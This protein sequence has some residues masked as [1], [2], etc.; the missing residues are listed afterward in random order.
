MTYSIEYL[1]WDESSE[2]IEFELD[3][4][5]KS[6]AFVSLT[7]GS[8]TYS[9]PDY[10]RY[11]DSSCESDSTRDQEFEF[12]NLASN[13]LTA[14][15]DYQITVALVGLSTP[16]PSSSNT[17]TTTLTSED[18]IG[19]DE[20]G[21]EADDFGSL[22][23]T[24]FVY[25]GETYTVEHLKWDESSEE[26]E[27][28]L[29][30]CLK[31]SVFIS[32]AI[33][34]TTYSNPDYTRRSETYCDSNASAYQEF[35]FHDITSNPLTD[36]AD[37]QITVT[38]VGN[39]TPPDPSNTT[40]TTTLTSEDEP[41]NDEFG[42]EVDDF[43]SLSDATFVYDGETYTVEYLKWD[44]S[45]DEIEFELDR[46]LKP[47][48]FVS[49]A[50]GSTTYSNPDYTRRS[51]TYC[52]S[53][54]SAYQEFEFHDIT[55]NPLTDGAD[56]QIT[57]TLVGISTP[58]D[59]GNTTWTTTLTSEDEP[60]DDEFGYEA[61]DFGS[62]SDATFEYDG[63]TYTVVY[64]KWDES[65]DEIEFE[66]DRCLKPS[67][68]ISLAIG[69]TTYSN[70]DYTRRSETYCDSN[71]SAYQEFEFHDITS[72]PL[73]AGTDYQITVTL[74]GNSSAPPLFTQDS[75]VV[76]ITENVGDTT[77][78]VDTSASDPDGGGIDYS[79]VGGNVGD[80]FEISSRG[81]ISLASG[82]S[83][84]FE[85][86]SIY[87][88]TLKAEDRQT[89]SRYGA[90]SAAI[91]VAN[92]NESPSFD[93]D[94]YQFAIPTGTGSDEIL[95]GAVR[96]ADPDPDDTVV[97]TIASG[98]PADRNC[99]ETAFGSK[100]FRMDTLGR[101]WACPTGLIGTAANY[102]L[103]V[104]ATD[105]GAST[106]TT[107]VAVKVTN[108][109]IATMIL[110][111]HR[112]AE[113]DEFGVS[114][115]LSESRAAATS[116]LLDIDT[117]PPSSPR[118]SR[119]PRS[120]SRSFTTPNAQ[121]RVDFDLSSTYGFDYP[122][123]RSGSRDLLTVETSGSDGTEMAAKYVVLTLGLNEESSAVISNGVVPIIV[124]DK[125]ISIGES[126][127]GEWGIIPS[128]GRLSEPNERQFTFTVPSDVGSKNVQI[129]LTSGYRDPILTLEDSA[130]NVVE[131]ND[132]GGAGFN[133]R[134]V[135]H[136]PAGSYKILAF[137]RWAGG[138]GDFELTISYSDEPLTDPDD[139]RSE[140]PEQA[141]PER[142]AV[143][144]ESLAITGYEWLNG[145]CADGGISFADQGDAVC[146]EAAGSGFQSDD[147]AIAVLS[148]ESADYPIALPVA[149][150]ALEYEDST[151][152]RGKWVAQHLGRFADS[153][154][155]TVYSMTIIGHTGV[156][157]GTLSVGLPSAPIQTD[158]QFSDATSTLTN[159]GL[160]DINAI[161]ET[162]WAVFG[163]GN[164]YTNYQDFTI[165]F[166]KGAT[167]GEWGLD[168]NPNRSI[169]YFVGW[170]VI[171][172]IPGVDI[173]PDLR[174]AIKLEVTRCSG[175]LGCF[176]ASLSDAVDFLA[177]IP[178]I[179]KIGDFVQLPKI[180]KWA[181]D[182]RTVRKGVSFIKE[183]P[184]MVKSFWNG[185]RGHWVRKSHNRGIILQ[186]KVLNRFYPNGIDL[187]KPGYPSMPLVDILV[188]GVDADNAD[189]VISVKS[190]N[191]RDETYTENPS[192]IFST[193]KSRGYNKLK[194]EMDSKIKSDI[195]MRK[196]HVG[197]SMLKRSLDV[198]IPPSGLNN[199]NQVEQLKRLVC[200]G[201]VDKADKVADITVTIYYGNGIG[202]LRKWVPDE[203][204]DKTACR[205]R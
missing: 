198:V 204:L 184:Y 63:E 112:L 29:D 56:Y 54:A 37:Y 45:Q 138:Q 78:I 98:N 171:G 120:Q 72:N 55:S 186:N 35:E 188:R 86:A 191:T 11:R 129:D 131:W 190:L 47:S 164:G 96:A 14:G 38:L 89:A 101:I 133:A 39:S 74:V 31:P 163:E 137:T 203:T 199:P 28:Q 5:L 88:L 18:E 195:R 100:L 76:S 181:A 95:A 2:E 201:V 150:V 80:I 179:G 12:Q 16:P 51:E 84:D 124:Y 166:A 91:T 187:D 67:V 75:Y 175:W 183:I 113:S 90:A 46:C 122:S 167:L 60:G 70:P 130:G 22:S 157:T 192:K 176:K 49:L 99:T 116:L 34:S 139:E 102:S 160:T 155:Q 177:I 7:I 53:N 23:D 169:A 94:S 40:W 140:D 178:A 61:D 93:L 44:E 41:G 87:E 13:P 197:T 132:D 106:D 19:D 149:S 26:I 64:L 36:G 172:F 8:T 134:I 127:Q 65:Q 83:L 173:A 144:I 194:N 108:L 69:S 73:T 119:S 146:I 52:D 156:S 66:L 185:N 142:R 21:Y 141:Y 82:R 153:H 174:D 182:S 196:E 200:L 115:G 114:V 123:A 193:L 145:E 162:M 81:Q 104:T 33:G 180:M 6:S 10:T 4:C 170:A 68:F 57:V 92:I 103:T 58:P 107:A 30:T 135:R 148:I 154:N 109:P 152:L 161:M 15:S 25:D 147:E 202:S 1:K 62:L 27:F 20:F 110:D 158:S 121:G 48:A 32:L 77:T 3:K 205:G 136:L 159:L 126:H 117:T 79:I 128:N 118:G 50:I 125:N 42:Y 9:S 168:S 43:G 111:Y 71:A 17:W 59:P 151:T 85:L 97:Y 189:R 24:T 143:S 165:D 105:D